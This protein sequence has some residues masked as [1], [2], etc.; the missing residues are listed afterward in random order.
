MWGLLLSV[1]SFEACTYLMW[2]FAGSKSLLSFHLADDLD[3][4]TDQIS[5]GAVLSLVDLPTLQM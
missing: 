1:L 2:A 5:S 3:Q 4:F